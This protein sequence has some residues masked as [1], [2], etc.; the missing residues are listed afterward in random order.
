M[1]GDGSGPG[2]RRRRGAG[3][4]AR[5]PARGIRLIRA[6]PILLGAITLDL[7]AVLFGGAVALLPLFARSI[8][9][10]GPF[11]LGVLR[12]APAVGALVAGVRLARRPLGRHAGRTLLLVVGAFGVEH[13]RLRA[14]ALVL[15]VA[16]SRSR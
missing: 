6:T 16:R 9:H 5:E 12:S 1:G 2:L 14:L 15:A 13:D 10:T 4:A 7:F 8:L 3:A 11:G